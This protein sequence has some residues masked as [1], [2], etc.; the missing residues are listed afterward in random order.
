MSHLWVQGISTMPGCC[1]PEIRRYSAVLIGRRS[2]IPVHAGIQGFH[3]Q[4]SRLRQ[5]AP[6]PGFAGVT[7]GEALPSWNSRDV[8]PTSV[9][10]FGIV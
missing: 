2:V 5:N 9:L 10:K 7:F 6:A 8:T 1:V 3:R 4:S